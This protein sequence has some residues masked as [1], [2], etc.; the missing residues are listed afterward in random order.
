MV[1]STKSNWG[2]EGFISSYSLQSIV[3]RCQGRNA[4]AGTEAKAMEEH[5]LRACS[6]G[7][8]SPAFVIYPGTVY[9]VVELPTVD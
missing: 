6:P 9:P 7:S 2:R 5:Y 1:I 3:E 8:C 4:E